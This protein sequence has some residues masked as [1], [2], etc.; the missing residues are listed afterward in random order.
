[1]RAEITDYKEKLSLLDNYIILNRPFTT[2]EVENSVKQILISFKAGKKL[3]TKGR[4]II[5]EHGKKR[6]VQSGIIV[7][8][9]PLSDESVYGKIKSINRR[10][11][12]KY[13]FENPDLIFKPYIRELVR[14]RLS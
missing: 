9:G 12:V 8:R 2:Q 14:E 13:L 5:V 4:R 7:P 11:P 1:M 6:V 3:A 10:M